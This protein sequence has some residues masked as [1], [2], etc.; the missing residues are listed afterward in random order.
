MHWFKFSTDFFFQFYIYKK[1]IKANTVP[2]RTTRQ[3][4]KMHYNIILFSYR[5][6]Y[7]STVWRKKFSLVL[8]TNCYLHVFFFFF[9]LLFTNLRSDQYEQ[10]DR[11]H[12]KHF[13]KAILMTKKKKLDYD[14]KMQTVGKRKNTWNMINFLTPSSSTVFRMLGQPVTLH[15]P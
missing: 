12:T 4:T 7:I 13:V 14:K 8:F 9:K 11:M 1:I 3:P 15:V 2:I 6:L 5:R 10:Y